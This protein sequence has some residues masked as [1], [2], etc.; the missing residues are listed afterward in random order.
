MAALGELIAWTR[1]HLPLNESDLRKQLTAF[2]TQA[3]I[4][5]I[6]VLLWYTGAIYP[7]KSMFVCDFDSGSNNTYIEGLMWRV[8]GAHPMGYSLEDN[9][10]GNV[11]QD[12]GQFT[13]LGMDAT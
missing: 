12:T 8:I 7:S 9:Y 2:P 10:W 5:R 4:A 6:I 11:P 13:G 3:S 1:A